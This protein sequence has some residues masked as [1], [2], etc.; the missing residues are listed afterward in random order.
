MPYTISVVRDILAAAFSLKGA[1]ARHCRGSL[2]FRGVQVSSTT[3]QLHLKI[4]RITS[5][6]PFYDG[7]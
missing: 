7:S 6:E 4:I 5:L 1:Q 2:H 3:G